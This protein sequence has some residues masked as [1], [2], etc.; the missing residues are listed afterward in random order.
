MDS[1][2]F[3]HHGHA[4]R[5]GRISEPGRIYLLTAITHERKAVS[6]TGG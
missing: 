4:L 3:A 1:S 5:R 6:R 2:L